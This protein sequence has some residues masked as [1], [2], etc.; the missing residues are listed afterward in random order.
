M[1]FML[2][3]RELRGEKNEKKK[4]RK[5]KNTRIDNGTIQTHMASR[6][7]AILNRMSLLV[8]YNPESMNDV[9]SHLAYRVAAGIRCGDNSRMFVVFVSGLPVYQMAGKAVW[10]LCL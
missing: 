7:L 10:A 6:K 5:Q 2:A 9:Y 4:E 3:F 1:A 8:Q